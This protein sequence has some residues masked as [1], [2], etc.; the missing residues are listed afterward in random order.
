MSYD[1]V[2]LSQYGGEPVMLYRFAST[3]SNKVWLYT[4]DGAPVVRG[5]E[6]YE[7]SAIRHGG[8]EQNVTEGP[9]PIEI[10]LPSS[11]D[12]AAQFRSF[13]PASPIVVT[14]F[15]RHRP[16]AEFVTIFVGECETAQY[17]NEGIATIPAQPFGYKL[18]RNVPWPRFCG[19]CNWAL[20]SEGC[21]VSL[22]PY[23]VDVTI[24]VINGL[25]V[26][27]AALASKPINWFTAGFAVRQSTGE[28][29]WCVPH[30]GNRAILISAFPGLA[31]G[32]VVS[33]Y[34]GC[35]GSET[36]CSSKFDNLVN[37]MG[38]PDVPTKNPYS[39]NIN[40]T[41]TA[42]GGGAAFDPA[43]TMMNYLRNN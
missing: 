43:A 35:D 26:Q 6:T 39:D 2:Q 29:R 18:R 42:S 27:A 20:Y 3:S 1:S 17:D 40:G 37:H 14:V 16:D 9:Q 21:G 7:S 22:E 28:T 15:A 13:L 24:Q 19:P 30:D 12:L 34:A 38:F 11:T 25:E 23:R 5:S 36:T 8:I 10:T 31:A 41:G 4:N 32:E 33:F